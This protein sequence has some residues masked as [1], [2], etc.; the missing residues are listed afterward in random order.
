VVTGGTG[1]AGIGSGLHLRHVDGEGKVSSMVGGGE[2]RSSEMTRDGEE[3]DGGGT[4][5]VHRCL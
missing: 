5:V 4:T 2:R 3:A 1:V